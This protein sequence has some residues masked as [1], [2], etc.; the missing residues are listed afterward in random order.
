M[1]ELKQK[2]K[3]TNVSVRSFVGSDRN[4]T[5]NS[6]FT[7][8]RGVLVAQEV[9]DVAIRSRQQNARKKVRFLSCIAENRNCP[10]IPTGRGRGLKIL[11]VSVRIRG[12]APKI[13]VDKQPE[14]V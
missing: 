12:R 14:S 7:Y 3:L 4:I 11:S 9:R 5:E 10:A 8:A 6:V 2:N 1:I 13:M